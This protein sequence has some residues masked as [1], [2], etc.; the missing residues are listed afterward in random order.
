M[1]Q[2]FKEF[3]PSF[4]QEPDVRTAPTW[5]L[6]TQKRVDNLKKKKKMMTCILNYEK[7]IRNYEAKWKKQVKIANRI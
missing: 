4:E 2:T 7:D 6:Q 5:T 1:K 3:Y